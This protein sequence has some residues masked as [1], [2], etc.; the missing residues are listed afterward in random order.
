MGEYLHLACGLPWAEH[1]RTREGGTVCPD[2][3]TYL[4]PFRSKEEEPD[5]PI[6][7]LFDDP[8]ELS[9]EN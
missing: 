1:D 4:P 2:H 9:K 3:P 5:P 6:A 7:E 8:E